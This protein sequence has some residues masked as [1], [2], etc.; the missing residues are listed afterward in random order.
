LVEPGVQ[1]SVQLNWIRN[2]DLDPDTAAQ[3]RDAL[4]QNLGMAV[5]NHRLGELARADNPPFIGAGGGQGT[6]FKT[7]DLGSVSA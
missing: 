1:S 5:L 4:L 7:L 2:P 3:R 6:L